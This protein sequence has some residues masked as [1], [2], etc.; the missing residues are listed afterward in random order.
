MR[1]MAFRAV[2]LATAVLAILG[3]K[4]S[5]A[6][7]WPLILLAPLS[8]LGIWDLA[9]TKH[10]LLRNYPL[11]AHFRWM[12]EDIRPEIQQYFV[13]SDTDGRPF[14]RDVRTQIY[15]RAKDVN[16]E[17]AFG[18]EL[19]VYEARGMP[20]RPR[21]CST[22]NVRLKPTM[23]IQKWIFPNRSFSIRPDILGNQ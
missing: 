17:S 5:P 3:A 11:L 10:S 6:F 22:K 18:T 15:E 1:Y 14:D 7:L 4:L 20:M 9:Q 19:D 2:L 8:L 21:K 23:V 12:F 16:Q 13:E